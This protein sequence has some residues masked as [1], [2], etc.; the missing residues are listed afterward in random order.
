MR[1][2]KLTVLWLAAVV[3]TALVASTTTT[4]TTGQQGTQS[5]AAGKRGGDN[6]EQAPVAKFDEADS[7]DPGERARR[8]E[9]GRRYDRQELVPN[10]PTGLNISSRSSH[11]TKDVP[12]IP[13]AQSDVIV[14]GRITDARA[15]LSP[16]KSGIYSEFTIN[17]EE[18][19]K[20]DGAAAISN[21]A[22]VA[23]R[24][25]GDV[26]YS[27]GQVQRIRPQL[28]QR[29]PRAGGRYLLFLK[30]VK[31]TLD[32]SILTGY[33]LA[34]SRVSALDAVAPYTSHEGA[35][36]FGFLDAVRG[37]T[38]GPRPPETKGTKGGRNQ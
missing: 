5:T 36:E 35:D 20:T 7:A 6:K 30:F 38:G 22:L 21:N 16:D 27:T 28:G 15:H 23:E 25:G 29:M 26:Q 11:W 32:L 33:E 10:R 8:Q 14:I 13:A 4:S 3:V 37:S 9:K 12:A 19:L 34:E 31:G 1:N 18:L 2:H 24:A 17:I